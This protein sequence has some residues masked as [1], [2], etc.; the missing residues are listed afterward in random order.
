MILQ[1]KAIKINKSYSS[2]RENK[3]ASLSEIHDFV[4]K[5]PSLTREYQYLQRHIN[6]AGLVKGSSNSF[7]FQETWQG[8]RGMLEGEPF[9]D[10]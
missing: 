4:K 2:F 8:E 5:I 10:Q 7:E 9:L 3:D 6:I 1:D